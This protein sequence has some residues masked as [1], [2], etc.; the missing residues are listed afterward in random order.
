MYNVS[1]FTSVLNVMLKLFH[2]MSACT[3]TPGFIEHSGET[4]VC[5]YTRGYPASKVGLQQFLSSTFPT[6]YISIRRSCE[7][8]PPGFDTSFEVPRPET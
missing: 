3:T 5:L 4:K 7:P 1:S 8:T 6:F 2:F